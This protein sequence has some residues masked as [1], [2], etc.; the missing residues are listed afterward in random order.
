MKSGI[1]TNLKVV[2]AAELPLFQRDVRP[3]ITE[4]FL[5]I[6]PEGISAERQVSHRRGWV[7]HS[8]VLTSPIQN[9][10]HHG[11]G[12]CFPCSVTHS[13]REGQQRVCRELQNIEEN[14]NE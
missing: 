4:E 6:L 7:Q 3:G 12:K 10:A 1:C 8:P 5:K 13:L 9:L 2:I 14:H 11:L